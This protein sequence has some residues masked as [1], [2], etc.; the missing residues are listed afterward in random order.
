M[1]AVFIDRVAAAIVVAE[2]KEAGGFIEANRNFDAAHD[3]YTVYRT[4]SQRDTLA[5]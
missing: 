3:L 4:P 5:S 2:D 1:V